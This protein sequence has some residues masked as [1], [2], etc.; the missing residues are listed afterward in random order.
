MKWRYNRH[1]DRMT[2]HDFPGECGEGMHRFTLDELELGARVAQELDDPEQ[3]WWEM[4]AL[5]NRI[6]DD[7]IPSGSYED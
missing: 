1:T 6:Y 5:K 2:G 4:D 7:L 3:W